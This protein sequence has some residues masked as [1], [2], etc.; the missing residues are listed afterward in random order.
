MLKWN[1]DLFQ[2]RIAFH[3]PC[4]KRMPGN[5]VIAFLQ[6]KGHRYQVF[7]PVDPNGLFQLPELIDDIDIPGVFSTPERLLSPVSKHV[8]PHLCSRG[9]AIHKNSRQSAIGPD[10][11]PKKHNR[12]GVQRIGSEI[13]VQNRREVLRDTE[14]F[15]PASGRVCTH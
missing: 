9:L 8:V 1:S 12:V 13:T 11:L 6:L 10:T 3:Q 7:K 2:Q 14:I 15:S 4:R 5:Y